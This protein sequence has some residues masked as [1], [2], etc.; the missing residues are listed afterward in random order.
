M[1]YLENLLSHFDLIE[2]FVIKTTI[3][4]SAIIVCVGYIWSHIKGL[5]NKNQN[6]KNKK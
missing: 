1:E 3:L 6:N 2:T 5:G 4:I